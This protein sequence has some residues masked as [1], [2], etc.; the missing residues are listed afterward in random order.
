MEAAALFAVAGARGVKLASAV[1]L[2]AVFG[3]PVGP[4]HTDS[5]IAFGRLYDVFLAAIELLATRAPGP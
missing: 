1:V 3:N 4:P 2:D 5:A